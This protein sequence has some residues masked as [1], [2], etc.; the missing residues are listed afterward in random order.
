MM[1][2]EEAEAYVKKLQAET[3]ATINK[4]EAIRKMMNDYYYSGYDKL[5]GDEFSA[6][7]SNILDHMGEL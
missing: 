5:S 2:K 3:S 4:A 1:L 7:I 6:I